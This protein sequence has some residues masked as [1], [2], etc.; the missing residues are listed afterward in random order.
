M[1]PDRESEHAYLRRADGVTYICPWQTRLRCLL[2]YGPYALDRGLGA[3][4]Q[5]ELAVAMYKRA[6]G[7]WRA[8]A[9][10]EMAN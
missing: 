2:S 8:L 5:R 3:A 6:Q 9:E 10:Y 7:R 1:V 4:G